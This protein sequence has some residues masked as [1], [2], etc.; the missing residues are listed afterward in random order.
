MGYFHK[1]F[2]YTTA[3]AGFTN[4][5]NYIKA[6]LKINSPQ[7]VILRVLLFSFPYDTSYDIG[8]EPILALARGWQFGQCLSLPSISL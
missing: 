4:R 3:R 2:S 5:Q 8:E 1:L 7:K 6:A